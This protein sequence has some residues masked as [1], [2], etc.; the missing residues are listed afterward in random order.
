LTQQKKSCEEFIFGGCGGNDNNFENKDS[1]L[2]ACE[3]KPIGKDSNDVK[4]DD[5][6]QLK[7]VGPCRASIPRFHFDSKTKSCQKFVFGGCMPNGNNFE[8]LEA[9]EGKCIKKEQ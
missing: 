5:C 4:I 1:C 6:L 9:C 7:E 2:A 8:T 3:K